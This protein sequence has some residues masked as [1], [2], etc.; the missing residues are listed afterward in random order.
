MTWKSIKEHSTYTQAEL[1]VLFIHSFVVAFLF[2]FDNWGNEVFS[3][4]QGIQNFIL[5][6]LLA[7]FVTFLLTWMIKISGYFVGAHPVFYLSWKSVMVSLLLIFISRGF[8]IFFIPPF[9]KFEPKH[10]L[11]LGRKPTLH[12]LKNLANVPTLALVAMGLFALLI[13]F[14]SFIPTV[15]SQELFAITLFTLLY[16]LIPIEFGIKIIELFLKVKAEKFAPKEHANESSSSIGALIWYGSRILFTFILAFT[17]AL[18]LFAYTGG[19]F[20]ALILT[21]IS[22]GIVTVVYMVKIEF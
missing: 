7:L 20:W 19:F 22:A 6:F 21:L 14:V 18:Q 1:L 13:R 11:A 8:I 17:I 15:V 5:T 16:S 10:H 12:A 4:S 9:L 3:Y 2:S